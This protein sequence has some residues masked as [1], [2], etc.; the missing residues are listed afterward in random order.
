[1]I[2]HLSKVH[3]GR[4]IISKK[5]PIKDFIAGTKIPELDVP[6]D[7][8]AIR[9]ICEA[10]VGLFT[11]VTLNPLASVRIAI[12]IQILPNQEDQFV[13]IQRTKPENQNK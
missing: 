1:M 9:H 10:S 7:P 5:K 13:S 6:F 4:Y 12:T 11:G 2:G 3:G 8:L